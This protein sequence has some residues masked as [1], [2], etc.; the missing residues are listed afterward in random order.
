M[1]EHRRA[2]FFLQRPRLLTACKYIT[3]DRPDRIPNSPSSATMRSHLA[4]TAILSF[5]TATRSAPSGM[6]SR[7][8]AVPG[9]PLYRLFSGT[10]SPQ[11]LEGLDRSRD[12]FRSSRPFLSGAVKLDATAGRGDTA[13]KNGMYQA[14]GG[15]RHEADSAGTES[16]SDASRHPQAGMKADNTESDADAGSEAVVAEV[17]PDVDNGV[18]DSLKIWTEMS[19]SLAASAAQ[20][21]S[22]SAPSPAPY[23]SDDAANVH[24]ATASAPS[25]HPSALTPDSGTASVEGDLDSASVTGGD[26]DSAT[27]TWSSAG[28]T[29]APARA[30]GNFDADG[31]PERR[32][33][34]FGHTFS[35]LLRSSLKQ[36]RH[37]HHQKRPDSR[38]TGG[39]FR[40]AYLRGRVFRRSTA[41]V[42]D[43]AAEHSTDNGTQRL[44]DNSTASGSLPPQGEAG[45]SSRFTAPHHV[46]YSNSE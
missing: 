3:D 18:D 45:G 46:I 9:D 21:H 32:E 1:C 38:S 42:N 20:S 16:P 34:A 23:E 10:D 19:A 27:A 11:S 26:A 4:W 37:G 44:D 29:V 22:A 14:D 5:L 40:H 17:T 15:H 7:A 36:L 35:H 28:E 24:F 2:N 41:G 13:S 43:G 8:E 31:S 39:A 33:R 30:G 25:P 6:V 12:D